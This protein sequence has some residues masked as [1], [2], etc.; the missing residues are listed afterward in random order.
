[1]IHAMRCKMLLGA[2]IVV[3]GVVE[4]WGWATAPKANRNLWL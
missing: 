3:L 4:F 1:M 2:I